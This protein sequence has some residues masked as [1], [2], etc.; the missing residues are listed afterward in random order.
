[1]ESLKGYNQWDEKAVHELERIFANHISDT[2]LI[3][4]YKE[5]PYLNNDKKAKNMIKK[6][7]QGLGKKKKTTFPQRRHTRRQ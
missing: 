2:R 1:M 4:I 6:I 5:L 3:A 7:G